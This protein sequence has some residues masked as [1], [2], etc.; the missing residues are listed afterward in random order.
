MT[1]EKL[2]YGLKQ[3]ERSK[4]SRSAGGCTASR[5]ETLTYH[6]YLTE[7]DRRFMLTDRAR[8]LLETRARLDGET[9]T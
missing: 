7:I 1:R 6:G 3:F 5:L 2:E 4:H 8:A 9:M